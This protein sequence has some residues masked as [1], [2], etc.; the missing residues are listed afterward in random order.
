[1][2]KL[3]KIAFTFLILLTVIF[4][5]CSKKSDVKVIKLGHGLDAS[6]PVHIAMEF[7]SKELVKNSN[8]KMRIDIY[9]SQQLGTERECVELLQIGSLGMTKVSASV[10]EGFAP[11]YTIFNLPYVFRD[12]EHLFSIL[13]GE[14]GKRILKS[15]EKKLIRGV[16]YFDAGSRSFYTKERPINSPD[17]LI[18]L[19]IRTQESATSVKLVNALGGSATPIS[20][21]ELYTALQQGVVD[22]AENNPPSFYLSRH[23]E[24]CKYYSL[25]EHTTVPDVLIISTKIWNSL[26][27]E[28]QEWF[29]AAVDAAV[30]YQRIIWKEASEDALKKVAESGVEI[31][32]PDKKPF[33]EKVVSLYE[34][35]K[36]T[37]PD[38]YK[39]LQEIK[40]K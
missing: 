26:S 28:E 29:Q 1:M 5:G 18:G 27:E 32:Y 9:P 20:W 25:D 38:I 30:I 11:S 6:H 36:K 13:D 37:N 17:D 40:S 14:I 21:G 19:K 12:A 39:L 34:E 15:S 35:Y 8:G 22:G 3:N 4:F 16:C 23:Y 2:M 33:E 31:I 10:L 7:M 24:V